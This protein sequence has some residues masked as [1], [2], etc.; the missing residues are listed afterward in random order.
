[1]IHLWCFQHGASPSYYNSRVGS[2]P[3]HV[4]AQSAYVEV[5]KLLLN[6]NQQ[7]KADPNIPTREGLTAF[8]ILLAHLIDLTG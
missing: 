5:I 8:H 3:I 2:A 4:A 1:M 6:K 7:N